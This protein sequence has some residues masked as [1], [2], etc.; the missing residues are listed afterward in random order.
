[1]RLKVSHSG[2]EGYQVP[3]RAMLPCCHDALMLESSQGLEQHQEKIGVF[4]GIAGVDGQSKQPSK[5]HFTTPTCANVSAQIL[6]H[7]FH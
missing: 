7:N 2:A 5:V 6:H 4:H 1:M 3:A